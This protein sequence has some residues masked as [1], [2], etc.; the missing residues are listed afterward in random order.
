MWDYY[1]EDWW[2][3]R[4]DDMYEVDKYCVG[5]EQKIRDLQDQ[6]HDECY[7]DCDFSWS[8]CNELVELEFV[9]VDVEPSPLDEAIE[10]A[11]KNKINDLLDNS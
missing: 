5:C 7:W 8:D 11:E 4:L 9:Y 10:E 3:D 2:N 1:D 6:V